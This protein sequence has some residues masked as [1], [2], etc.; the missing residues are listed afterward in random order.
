MRFS[1]ESRSQDRVVAKSV[2][3]NRIGAKTRLYRVVLSRE[4][5]SWS[6][7]FEIRGIYDG[8]AI[9]FQSNIAFESFFVKRKNEVNETESKKLHA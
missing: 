6:S 3:F 4:V 9:P 5:G 8:K 2:E 1:F 7:I